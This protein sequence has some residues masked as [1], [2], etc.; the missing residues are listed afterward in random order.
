MIHVIATLT[1]KAGTRAAFLKE[2]HKLVPRVHA[3]AGCIAY[4]PT[5]DVASGHQAQEPVRADVVIVVEQWES[6]AHLAAHSASTHMAEFWKKNGGMLGEADL[7][8]TEP[9]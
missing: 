3:E 6:L 9:V 1:L 7:V 8:V 2:F 4:A 5:V